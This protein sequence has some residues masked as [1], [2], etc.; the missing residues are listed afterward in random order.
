MNSDDKKWDAS[1]D[2]FFGRSQFVIQLLKAVFEGAN[3]SVTLSMKNDVKIDLIDTQL[4]EPEND[5]LQVLKSISVADVKVGNKLV[6][7]DAGSVSLSSDVDFTFYFSEEDDDTLEKLKTFIYDLNFSLAWKYDMNIYVDVVD[8][9]PETY[10]YKRENFSVLKDALFN[11]LYVGGKIDWK[12][13]LKV[14]RS[15]MDQLERGDTNN[16]LHSEK[17]VYSEYFER[18]GKFLSDQTS[19][20]KRL[21]FDAFKIEGSFL[22]ST[23]KV[24]LFVEGK[25]WKNTLEGCKS[26]DDAEKFL[27]SVLGLDNDLIQTFG[28]VSL[29]FS[30]LENMC[31]IYIH[32]SED[33]DFYRYTK[34]F[35]RMLIALM[36]LRATGNC[37]QEGTGRLIYY[38]LKF[39][40][41]SRST[42]KKN[43]A[44]KFGK[45]LALCCM[46]CI[47]G[48]EWEKDFDFLEEENEKRC[49]P[50]VF[51]HVREEV[52]SF[53]MK[54]L[55]PGKYIPVCE[56]VRKG[57]PICEASRE[58]AYPLMVNLFLL[59]KIAHDMGLTPLLESTSFSPSTDIPSFPVLP[60]PGDVSSSYKHVYGLTNKLLS[61]T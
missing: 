28:E 44:L 2:S 1:L 58:E 32:T 26:A 60:F 36:C 9:H 42:D 4:K 45:Y 20:E 8:Q 3:P 39:H 19:L 50:V 10:V 59:A 6:A 14:M 22:L 52:F 56:L 40:T 46:K 11:K 49:P 24:Y 23:L 48:E 33:S 57:T 51:Q 25:G 37:G 41:M 34:Y 15:F 7:K 43:H 5:D 47:Q 18:F 55:L 31:D 12:E 17:G 21:S 13:D 38:C 61:K 30:F 16:L 35:Q 53:V 27:L 29:H 54:S